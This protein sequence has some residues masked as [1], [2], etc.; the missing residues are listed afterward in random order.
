MVQKGILIKKFC[1]IK[2]V[3][4][5]YMILGNFYHWIRIWI[6]I[7]FFRSNSFILEYLDFW[8]QKSQYWPSF[9]FNLHHWPG[10]WK[11]KWPSV[12]NIEFE[13]YLDI[14][15]IKKWWIFKFFI[16]DWK[17]FLIKNSNSVMKIESKFWSILWFLIIELQLF[18]NKQICAK[19]I[20]NNPNSYS[21][22]KV[23]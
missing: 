10:I 23:A 2:Y 16:F 9:Q 11:Q 14:D 18:Q 8:D 6:I 17:S 3:L 13:N 21:V 15:Q 5:K 22:A 7:D 19:K 12:I 4:G 20:D 1:K